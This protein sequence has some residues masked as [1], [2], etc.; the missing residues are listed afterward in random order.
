MKEK[1]IIFGTGD[2][3]EIA[4]YYFEIDSNYEVVAFTV[5]EQ[6][7]NGNT[8]EGK[9]LIPF[10]R[11]EID[12]PS[13]EYVMFIA[14]SYAQMNKLRESKFHEAKTK[15]YKLA[16]YVSSRCTYLSQY[17][18]G[19]NCFIFEN[20][21]IQPFVHIGNNIT[22]WSGNHLGHHS[23]I[24]DNNF[25]TSH[26]VISGRCTVE[27]NCFIGVNSTIGHNVTLKKATLVGA[28][29]IITK[30]T[31]VDSV[32]VPSRSVKLEKKSSDIIL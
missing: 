30:N 1:L 21:T 32:Y 15:G 19:E 4:K 16:T 25:I 3:A 26:V 5:D 9:P 13:S 12:F 27:A 28:G 8:F 14:L 23:R 11:I 7:C 31:E 6:Y 24:E 17:L 29:S 2:I 22:L 10:E 20:N 18:P